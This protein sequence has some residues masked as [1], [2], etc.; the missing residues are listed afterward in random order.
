M[1]ENLLRLEVDLRRP[2][3]QVDQKKI[4]PRGED[5]F[6]E[7]IMRARVPRNFKTPDMD[8]Y[9]GMIDPS[10]HLNNFKSRMYLADASD[11]THCK[12]YLFRGLPE[13]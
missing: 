9:D 10:H 11:A 5:L 12:A 8:L 2:S 13:T 3:N 1:E 7:E 6:V 4:P